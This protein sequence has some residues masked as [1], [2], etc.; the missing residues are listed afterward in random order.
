MLKESLTRKRRR[1]KTRGTAQVCR[2][3]NCLCNFSAFPFCVFPFL[4]AFSFGV[5]PFLLA[6]SF[7]VFPFLLLRLKQVCHP[8]HKLFATDPP[9]RLPHPPPA[10]AP[11]AAVA[12]FVDSAP[13]GCGIA[14]ASWWCS[15][16]A[17]AG[18]C[19]HPKVAAQKVATGHVINLL[20]PVLRKGRAES[21]CMAE[22]PCGCTR[23]STGC[24]RP[25]HNQGHA[26]HGIATGESST[27]KIETLVEL[28]ANDS[29]P[30]TATWAQAR[31]RDRFRHRE[32]ANKIAGCRAD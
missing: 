22:D 6:F 18:C 15:F 30:P 32:L 3:A 14:V 2:L 31:S 5:F 8:C 28:P 11:V 16:S 9:R 10:L 24:E 4:L 26:A 13:A 27:L 20:V 7:G 17:T 21:R 25:H 23:H 12:A 1:S 19:G 29:T